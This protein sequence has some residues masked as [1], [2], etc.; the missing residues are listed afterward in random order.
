MKRIATF[1]LL[2]LALLVGCGTTDA[3]PDTDGPAGDTPTPDIGP[4][5]AINPAVTGTLP[6]F[7]I[8]PSE[9]PSWSTYILAAKAG[10]FNPAEGGEHGPLEK[11]WK[12]D[13]V[14]QPKDYD[15]CIAAYALGTSDATC[16]TNGD[17]LNVALSRDSTIILATSYSNGADKVIKRKGLTPEDMKSVP[18]YGLKK[19]V[20]EFLK[21]AGMEKLNL[22]PNDYKFENLDP[23]AAAT[24]LQNDTGD[25]KAICVWNPYA[26]QTL[27][28]AS[29]VEVWFDSTLIPEVIVDCVVQSNESLK[30]EGGERFAALVCDCYYQVNEKL[31]SDDQTVADATLTALGKDFSKLPLADMKLV[32]QETKFYSTP[33]AG[34]DLLSSDK[35]KSTM[36]YVVAVCQKIEVLKPGEQP[37]IG[38]NDP[39]KQLNFTTKYMEKVASG[40]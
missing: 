40:N 7:K 35:F 33:K 37:T 22:D 27:R 12:V 10:L 38:Y 26:M 5:P 3:P 13:V 28:T 24:A 21:V 14:M 30:R 1:V 2:A 18:I 32:V 16:I 25:V 20:S 31:F 9:Y 4:D 39:S 6:V 23:A 29:D 34:I 36:D 19:S 15:P 17:V 8:D 11:K